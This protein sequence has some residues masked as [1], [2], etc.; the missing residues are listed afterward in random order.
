MWEELKGGFSPSHTCIE[1]QTIVNLFKKSDW[2]PWV[3]RMEKVLCLIT[4]RMPAEV[5][6]IE[7]SAHNVCL[8]PSL[9]PP[10][11]STPFFPAP[12]AVCLA[13]AAWLH[14]LRRR[15]DTLSWY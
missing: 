13:S 15:T 12:Q 1:L 14:S 3:E 7:T 4:I 10:L 9:R 8:L 6:T 5:Y 2:Q 11:D